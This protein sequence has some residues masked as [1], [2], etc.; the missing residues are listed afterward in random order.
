MEIPISL[1]RIK[2]WKEK[3]QKQHLEIIE[4]ET[5]E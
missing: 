3:I 1:E 2:K 4:E 5:D